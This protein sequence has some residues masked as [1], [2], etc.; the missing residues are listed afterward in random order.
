MLNYSFQPIGY[1]YRN[2]TENEKALVTE[3][4][5]ADLVDWLRANS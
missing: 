1:E 4:E 5:F 2:L 3:K